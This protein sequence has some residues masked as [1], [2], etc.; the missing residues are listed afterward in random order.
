MKSPKEVWSRAVELVSE[1]TLQERASLMS[2]SSFWHLQPLERLEL[3]AVMVADG[4]HGLRKAD[5]AVDQAGLNA[6]V[7][8]TCFPTAVTLAS[9]WDIDLLQEVGAAIGRECQAEDVAVLLGPGVNIKRNPLC[10]RNFEY[11]SEDP[12]LSGKLAAKFIQGVPPTTKNR[13]VWLS[14]LWLIAAP[15]LSFIC[16][17]LK[18]QSKKRS[19][20]PLCALITS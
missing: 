2:G 16:R 6:S 1:M 14:T 9:S 13:A 8:A 7:P 5:M 20:G 3:D 19:P 17:P 4:P 10:G 18:L 11:Y 15:C 12:F